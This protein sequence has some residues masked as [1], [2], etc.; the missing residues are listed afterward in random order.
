M[1]QLKAIETFIAVV[2]NRSFSGAA[3]QLGSSN[4]SVT[5]HVNELEAYLGVSLLVRTTR[6]LSLTD[7][8]ATYLASVQQV[9]PQL[10]SA[11]ELARGEQLKPQGLLRIT[12]PTLF[13][14]LHVTPVI[15]HYLDLYPEASVQATFLDRQV[16]MIEEG[17]DAAVRIGHLADSGMRANKLTQVQWMICASPAYIEKY[18]EPKTPQDL[19]SHNIIGYGSSQNNVQWHFGNNQSF[20]YNTRCML[21]S[22][23]ACID[24]AIAGWGLTRILSYQANPHLATGKLLSVLRDFENDPIPVHFLHNDQSLSSAKIRAFRLLL[25]KSLTTL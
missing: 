3:R 22:V 9:L 16:S 4:A 8:G 17:F 1:D 12:A 15:R 10:H 21:N 13:G 23:S 18:G 24:C 19:N 11:T 6:S 25:A 14:Q 2:K 7:T 5:R 20:S